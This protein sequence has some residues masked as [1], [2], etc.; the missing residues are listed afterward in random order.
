MSSTL[1][2][3]TIVYMPLWRNWQTHWIQN[4][5]VA[6][7]YRFDPDQR[8]HTDLIEICDFVIDPMQELPAK[9]ESGFNLL[10]RT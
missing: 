10:L 3:R 2:D 7:S 5:A 1:I 4:P 6:I 8:H 9:E